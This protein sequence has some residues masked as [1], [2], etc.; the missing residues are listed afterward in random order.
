MK[1]GT[2]RAVLIDEL[3]WGDGPHE[4]IADAFV[5]QRCMRCDRNVEEGSHLGESGFYCAPCYTRG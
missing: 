3:L 4:H 1:T 2:N 5:E